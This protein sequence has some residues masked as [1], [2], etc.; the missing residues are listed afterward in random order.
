MIAST[1]DPYAGTT[2][3][4]AARGGPAPGDRA[5]RHPRSRRGLRAA[6]LAALAVPVL[7]ATAG[8]GGGGTPAARPGDSLDELAAKRRPAQLI[9]GT[10]DYGAG[11]IRISFLLAR[12]DGSL[13]L[14]PR[15]RIWI[16]ADRRSQPVASAIARL[17]S[18][19]A[20][21][22]SVN[23]L[24]TRSLYV[25][26]AEVAR[27]GKYELLV[28][29][30]GGRRF[31]AMSPLLVKA[32]TSALPVGARAPASATP[33]IASA[34]GDLRAITTHVPPDRALLRYS[35]AASL[36]A[37][38]PFVLLFASPAFCPNRTCGPIL[39]VV[40]SVRRRL[41]ASDVRFIHVEPYQ[42]NNPGL[43]FNHWA[44]EWR[45]PSEPFTYLIGGDGRVRAKFEGSISAAELLKAVRTMLL[46]RKV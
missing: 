1:S 34:H 14:Q 39:D 46:P 7:L 19:T 25:V 10:S 13:I 30:I 20:P 45:I 38:G 27:S 37:H 26:Q 16:A 21:G 40:D 9:S 3:T 6:V 2:R 33:T 18:V 43:G 15:A 11:Q 4:P 22:A 17:E 8:C 24:G 29:P 31:A 36:A 28:E 5:H 35:V 12:P 42:D 32:R 44:R 23:P 41:A